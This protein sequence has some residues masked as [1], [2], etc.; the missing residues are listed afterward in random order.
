M[1]ESELFRAAGA[2]ELG[3]S[4]QI[5]TVARRM[6]DNPQAKRSLEVFLSQWMRFDRVM[7]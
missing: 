5:R 6:L 4:E 1:P 3:T 7:A 2:G